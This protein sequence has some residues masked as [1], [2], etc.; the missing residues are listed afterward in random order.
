MKNKAKISIVIGISVFFIASFLL[1]TYNYGPLGV[2]LT[3]DFILNKIFVTSPKLIIDDEGIPLVNYGFIDVKYVGEQRNPVTISHK[4]FDYY[5][6]FKKTGNK[7]AKQYVINNAN[8]LVSNSKIHG[9]YSILYYNFSWPTYEMPNPW[10]SGMAQGLALRAL[11]NAHEISNDYRYL[12]AS[13]LLLNSFFVEIKNGGVTYKSPN[14]GWWYEEYA[15]EDG[16]ESRVLNGMMHALIGIHEYYQYTN[17]TK[18]K[19]LF[20]KGVVALKNDLASYDIEGHSY[21]DALNKVA[22]EKYHNAH[23]NLTRTMFEI[24]NDEI[25]KKYYQKW[26]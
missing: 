4:I 25:F 12:D 5:T 15:H 7:T 18:A 6:D 22:N 16:R 26:G 2:Q 14:D 19:Y 9:N 17:E 1:I 10:R 20:E 21:Y 11:S 24:T 3:L 8:W 13:N 23:V